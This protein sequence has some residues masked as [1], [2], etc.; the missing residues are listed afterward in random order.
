MNTFDRIKSVLD[1][2]D[3][4]QERNNYLDSIRKNP[5]I[6]RHDLV[7][8]VCNTMEETNFIESYY[9]VTIEKNFKTKTKKIASF[10]L[11]IFLL[12]GN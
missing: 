6:G 5:K 10:F 7:R 3:N 1:K 2:L 8:I 12:S 9:K 11:K 4:N